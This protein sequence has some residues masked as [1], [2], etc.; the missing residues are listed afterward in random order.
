[1]CRPELPGYPPPNRLYF[2]GFAG[3]MVWGG[4]SCPPPLKLTFSWLMR[5]SHR[6]CV[7]ELMPR[8]KVVQVRLRIPMLASMVHRSDLAARFVPIPV[9]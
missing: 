1:M 5:V 2:R 7:E 8:R 4:H 6:P 9:V 3:S